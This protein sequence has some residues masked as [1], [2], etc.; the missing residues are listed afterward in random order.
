[1]WWT[2]NT[3]HA[4]FTK[5]TNLSRHLKSA[6]LH[7]SVKCSICGNQYK[8]QEYLKK[9]MRSVHPEPTSTITSSDD[10]LT[11]SVLDFNLDLLDD[12]SVQE[13]IRSIESLTAPMDNAAQNLAPA[14][15]NQLQEYFPA[16]STQA[17]QPELATNAV[18]HSSIASQTR[19]CS[20][21]KTRKT[22]H[23][24]CGTSPVILRDHCTGTHISLTD[25]G[26]S[27]IVFSRFVDK[28]CSPITFDSPQSLTS[29]S[30]SPT[31]PLV[32]ETGIEHYFTRGFKEKYLTHYQGEDP[33]SDQDQ[34][35]TVN[36]LSLIVSYPI[37]LLDCLKD[38][39]TDKPVVIEEGLFSKFFS[40]KA[41]Q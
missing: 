39:Q 41:Y 30:V 37:R 3:C 16:I 21:P 20:L 27:P 8:R 29:S 9:H 32:S 35:T 10:L 33:L 12:N 28:G 11:S 34:D 17:I 38:K 26:C 40:A 15:A 25:K 5:K 4:T 36:D 22:T 23:T 14:P 18:N 1:M 2:C 13:T 31:T 24:A 6:H 19:K 7:Y